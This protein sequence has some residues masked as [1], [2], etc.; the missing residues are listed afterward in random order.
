[1]MHRRGRK[2]V[3]GSTWDCV[4]VTRKQPS[5]RRGLHRRAG[6]FSRRQHRC[7]SRRD[8][9]GTIN[10][11]VGPQPLS[12]ALQNDPGPGGLANVLT[13]SMVNPP[14]LT[15]G[16]LLIVEPGN[17]LGDVVRFTRVKG[18]PMAAWAAWFSTPRPRLSTASR[19]P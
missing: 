13:Y 18:V 12:F 7:D 9:H 3:D 4:P 14:G 11:F 1:M 15:A 19:T 17:G 10:G 8:G 6:R 2:R 16:D 5:C